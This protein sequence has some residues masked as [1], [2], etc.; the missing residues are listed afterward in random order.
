M[1]KE[2]FQPCPICGA[3]LD[4]NRFWSHCPRHGGLVCEKH[5]SRCKYQKW[6]G[7]ICRC[8]YLSQKNK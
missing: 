1:K 6:L 2:E 5:C 7:S 4:D 8:T 3:G